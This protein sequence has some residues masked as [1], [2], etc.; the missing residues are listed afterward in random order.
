MKDDK[1]LINLDDLKMDKVLAYYDGPLL[2]VNKDKEENYYLVYCCDV[3]EKEYVIAKTSVSEL[4]DVLKNVKSISFVFR[5]AIMK[6]KVKRDQ[7]IECLENFDDM[8]ILDDDVHLCDL[9]GSFDDYLESLCLNNLLI[10]SVSLK[11]MSKGFT[12]SFVFNENYNALVPSSIFFEHRKR[13]DVHTFPKMKQWK[14][15]R[16]VVEDLCLT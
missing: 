12:T 8:D 15:E 13:A 14:F 5:N 3:D 11:K 2:F 9:G 6:W 1:Q 7:S 10:N 16:E 4:I